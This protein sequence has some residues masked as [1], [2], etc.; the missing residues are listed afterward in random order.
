[1]RRP[2]KSARA[3]WSMRTE[4]R[5]RSMRS[6]R[7]ERW[8][9]WKRR[10]PRCGSSGC[11]PSADTNSGW[12]TRRASGPVRFA[13]RRRTR[14]MPSICWTCCARIVFRASGCRPWRSAICA[15]CW[16]RVRG[17]KLV[18]TR[19]AVKNQLHALAMSQG[20]C[21]KRKLW[22]AHGRAEL[23]SLA[24]LPW[25]TRRR[26]ELLAMLDQ[27]D[28]SVAE[29]DQAVEE[30]AHERTEVARLRTHPGVGAVVGLAF[31]LTLGPVE[32]FANSRKLVS[33]LG[34]NPREH[35]SGGR[36]RLGAI[37]K[38][39]NSMMRWLLVQAAQTAA[40]YDP[41]LR[42]VYQR[43]KFRRASGV[44]KVAIARRLA[45]RLYWMLRA[46]MD[47]AQLVRMSGSPSSAMVPPTAGSRV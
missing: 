31:V 45:V 3:G 44:A 8:W 39:G 29:L 40:R 33:Y 42:R 9:E 17:M 16:S 13:S 24:L 37:S 22:S 7:G 27:L 35:S 30:A 5:A 19:T 46:P 28:G 34:L 20:V 2:V 12:G 25:A 10:F 4:R 6:G 26:K 14:A 15:S 23:Q 21:R 1:M 18:R 47:Y 36:Q 43:L 11:W 41:E 32:R 38:Q